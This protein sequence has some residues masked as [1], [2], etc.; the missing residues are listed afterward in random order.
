MGRKSR[1]GPSTIPTVPIPVSIS[2]PTL[3]KLIPVEWCKHWDAEHL[4]LTLVNGSQVAFRSLDDPD[5]AHSGVGL[6]WAWF[7]EAAFIAEEAWDYF[8]PSLTDFAGAAFFTSSVDG[9]DW[10]YERIEKK[11]LIEHRP[12]YW[13][14]KWRTIDNP[15]MAMYRGAEIARS[16]EH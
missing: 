15:Y 14:A 16:E 12:G 9:F 5:R 13:A 11:A 10:T 6:H 2:M 3:L 1:S 8:E 7:D 4:M